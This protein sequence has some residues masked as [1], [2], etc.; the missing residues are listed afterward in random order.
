MPTN[1]LGPTNK[2]GLGPLRPT[3][4]NTA[5]TTTPFSVHYPINMVASL[6]RKNLAPHLSESNLIYLLTPSAST[7]PLI[8]TKGRRILASSSTNQGDWNRRFDPTLRAVGSQVEEEEELPAWSH[9]DTD[10]SHHARY[11]I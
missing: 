1:K 9:T 6:W 7:S 4:G 11:L 5:G 2:P 8:C 3:V 10:Q